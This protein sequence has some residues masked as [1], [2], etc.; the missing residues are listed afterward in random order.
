[1]FYKCT[2][3]IGF[4][5]PLHYH[6]EK[7]S[8]KLT[9]IIAKSSSFKTKTETLTKFSQN[10]WVINFSHESGVP[11]VLDDTSVDTNSLKLIQWKK[12]ERIILLLDN[13]R[14]VKHIQQYI[15]EATKHMT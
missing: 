11:G 2:K 14:K 15:L 6:L 13:F 5:E 7:T 10:I 12:I 8:D 9:A 4:K 1:M 3:I